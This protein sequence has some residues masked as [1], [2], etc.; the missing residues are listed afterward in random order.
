M[1]QATSNIGIELEKLKL[2]TEVENCSKCKKKIFSYT[3]DASLV[4]QGVILA[5]FYLL[6]VRQF[7]LL[8]EKPGLTN[9]T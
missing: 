1:A 4:E 5:A 2:K 6:R 7:C 9:A 8:N 3:A